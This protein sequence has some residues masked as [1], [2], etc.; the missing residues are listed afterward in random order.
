MPNIAGFTLTAAQ[1]KEI[2][3]ALAAHLNMEVADVTVA[4]A[5]KFMRQALVQVVMNYRQHQR[6]IDNP[7][8]KTEPF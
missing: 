4:T 8:D 6:D 1:A 2:R 5:R 7:V 3:D